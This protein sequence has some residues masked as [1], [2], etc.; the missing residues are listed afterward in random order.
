MSTIASELKAHPK[1]HLT[2][3]Y[4]YDKVYLQVPEC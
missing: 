3:A 4:S 1:T 2:A